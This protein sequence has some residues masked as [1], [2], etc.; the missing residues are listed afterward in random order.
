M[1]NLEEMLEEAF[2]TYQLYLQ[3]TGALTDNQTKLP[4]LKWPD[5]AQSALQY[6]RALES[7]LKEVGTND[8]DVAFV[9]NDSSNNR[10]LLEADL[11]I[12]VVEPLSIIYRSTRERVKELL[13]KEPAIKAKS[14]ENPIK[15]KNNIILALNELFSTLETMTGVKYSRLNKR[16]V[17]LKKGSY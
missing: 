5:V 6:A 15:H 7:E 13:E 2:H 8:I 12:A 3:C 16:Q 4:L 9:S 10:K 1:N 11:R 14:D 17:V